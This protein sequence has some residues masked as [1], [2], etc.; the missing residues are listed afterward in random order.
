MVY[1]L[2]DS[3]LYYKFLNGLGTNILYTNTQK[4][5]VC[6]SVEKGFYESLAYLFN[7]TKIKDNFNFAEWTKRY[8]ALSKANTHY[9]LTSS[10]FTGVDLSST[11]GFAQSML[12]QSIK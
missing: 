3:T 11:I 9:P 10:E 8:S 5:F 6:Q 7:K 2:G 1:V 12:N 4:A